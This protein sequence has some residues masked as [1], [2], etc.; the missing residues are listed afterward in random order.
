MYKNF[1][2]ITTLSSSMKHTWTFVI[3]VQ[4]TL[5]SLADLNFIHFLSVRQRYTLQIREIYVCDLI[6]YLFSYQ[7]ALRVLLISMKYFSLVLESAYVPNLQ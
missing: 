7:L 5:Y 4:K 6:M 3:S 1:L 2:P